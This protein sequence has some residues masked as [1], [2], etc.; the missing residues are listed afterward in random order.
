MIFSVQ[1][2]LTAEKD[3]DAL[4]DKTCEYILKRIYRASREPLHFL[5]RLHG[6]TLYK[7]RCGDYRIIVRLDTSNKIFGVVMVDHRSRVYKRFER[8]NK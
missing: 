1:I 3:L 2:S 4:D 8:L 6:Y 7:L 5:E